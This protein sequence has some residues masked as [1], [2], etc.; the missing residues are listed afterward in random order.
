VLFEF[1]LQALDSSNLVE[2]T[3]GCLVGE[4][5]NSFLDD[6]KLVITKFSK[7]E[8]ELLLMLLKAVLNMIDA[9]EAM[10]YEMGNHKLILLFH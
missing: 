4:D 8:P 1:L 10:K 9:Q 3:K 6:W 5:M 7:K 2:L